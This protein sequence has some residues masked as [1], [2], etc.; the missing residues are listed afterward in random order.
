MRRC[1]LL[2]LCLLL[3]GCGR[4]EP[5]KL[6]RVELP[7]GLQ[8]PKGLKPDPEAPKPLTPPA[9]EIEQAPSKED[10]VDETHVAGDFNSKGPGVEGACRYDE[11]EVACWNVGGLPDKRLTGAVKA[12]LSKRRDPLPTTF[13]RLNR[14]V[15]ASLPASTETRQ[16]SVVSGRRLEGFSTALTPARGRER[17]LVSLDVDPHAASTSLRFLER[18]RIPKEVPIFLRKGATASLAG[19]RLTVDSIVKMEPNDEMAFFLQGRPGWKITM[20]RSGKPLHGEKFFPVDPYPL[21]LADGCR[22]SIDSLKSGKVTLAP[23]T[24]P[25][26]QPIFYRRCP[27]GLCPS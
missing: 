3:L 20:L 6:T 25:R 4:E 7:N 2:A 15:V 18:K 5:T 1:S 16:L 21:V 13:G 10:A 22:A 12:L 11:S 8:K 14:L 24:A 9:Q 19:C 23:K 26:I 27:R 17:P